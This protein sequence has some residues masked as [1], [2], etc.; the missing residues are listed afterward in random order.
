[1]KSE[2]IYL[3]LKTGYSDNGPAW[4]GKGFY[5]KSGQSIYFNNKVFKRGSGISGNYYDIET[6]DEYWI[7]GVKKNGFDRHWAGNGKILIDRGILPEYLK[8][9]SAS[10]LPKNKFE[11][12]DLNNTPNKSL[13]NEIENQKQ[14]ATF[15]ESIRFKKS[16]ELTDK[17]LSE[18]LEYYNNM[19]LS[20]LPK[21]ARHSYQET[22][23]DVELEI[24]KRNTNKRKY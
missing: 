23:E 16:N 10:E 8:M 14:E 15:D 24:L 21:K 3:E 19:D 22:I 1:M 17:E 9:I 6:G 2:I 18:L 5:S 7:S 11:L 4:I 20:Q 12:V 13:A